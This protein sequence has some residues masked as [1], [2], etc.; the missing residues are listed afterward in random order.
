MPGP[1]GIFQPQQ[2]LDT[3]G[4]INNYTASTDPG[5]SNDATQ[6]F[7]AGSRWLN[8][9]NSRLWK[10]MSNSV[11]AAVWCLAGVVPGVGVEPSGMLTQ[12]GSSTASFPEE[13]NIY[14]YT[15]AT[16]V[17]PTSTSGDYV[18]GVYALPASGFDIANRGIQVTAAGSFASNGDSKTIKLAVSNTAQTLQAALSSATTIATTG[19]VATNGGGWQISANVFKYGAAGSNTQLAIHSQA[20]VGGAVSALQAPT[21]LTLTESSVIYFAVSANT[22]TGTDVV[23]N[24]VEINA[25]N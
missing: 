19:S 9:S 11:G 13:G 4:G 23:I 22:S 12:F 14:R 21:S 15:S 18:I 5:V 1:G 25:M 16:G 24:W 10:C 17:S 20:Q 3:G 2:A 7:M 6:G 8:L